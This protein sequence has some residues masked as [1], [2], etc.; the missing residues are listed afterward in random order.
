MVCTGPG[1]VS[2]SIVTWNF[3]YGGMDVVRLL[4]ILGDGYTKIL[5][6]LYNF[7]LV[8]VQGIGRLQL[9]SLVRDLDNR[10]LFRMETY[11]SPVFPSF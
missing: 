3:S 1:Y 4:E 11:L 10:A 6:T 7:Q 8:S 9:L 2:E 5:S